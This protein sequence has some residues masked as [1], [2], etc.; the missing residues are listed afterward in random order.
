MT[1]NPQNQNDST[2]SN[3]VRTITEPLSS[4]GWPKWLVYLLGL[5][6][7]VYILNP[8]LGVFEL[9]PDALPVVGN[10]DEGA[11]VVMIL[12]G[13]VEASESRKKHRAEK[14]TKKDQA[15]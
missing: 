2:R 15:G 1:S 3:F 4:R 8:S 11:A 10:L 14:Q 5:I 6:G 7:G 9:I 12:T 13:L